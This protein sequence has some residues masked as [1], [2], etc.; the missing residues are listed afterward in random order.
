EFP[1]PPPAA[2]PLLRAAWPLISVLNRLAGGAAARDLA[3]FKRGL[4]AMIDTFVHTAIAD[5]VPPGQVSAARYILCTALDEAVL[6]TAWGNAGDWNTPSLL[7]RFHGETWG[8]ETVFALLDR[9]RT[10]V[11]EYRGILTIGYIV[12]SLGFQGRYRRERDG[13]ALA[14]A[15]R[16]QLGEL[17]YPVPPRP[18]PFVTLAAAPVSRRQRELF[19]YAPVWTVAVF[20]A[21][22]S[23]SYYAWLDYEL[24]HDAAAVAVTL[25]AMP[26]MVGT[27]AP[28]A[29]PPVA[30]AKPS[31]T[32][33][34]LSVHPGSRLG[35]F[36][37]PGA[38]R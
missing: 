37:R 28:P 26:E 32:V 31:A 19:R 2:P 5:G 35:D 36:A 33:T 14:E 21:L 7:N 12:M 1:A 34:P 22:L 30:T 9:A 16:T 23:L 24:R 13:T 10:N 6:T 15:V 27:V 11:D 29:P 18:L 17:L 38:R 4:I 8:G 20:C 25:Q 3:R